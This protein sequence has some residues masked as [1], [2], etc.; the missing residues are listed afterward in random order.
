LLA[1]AA[2]DN[3]I[4]LWD[5]AS[6]QA[7]HEIDAHADEI[8]ALSFGQESAVLASASKDKTVKLWDVATG[9]LLNTLNLKSAVTAVIWHD[10]LYA[11][12]VGKE[13][14]F[15]D[16]KTAQITLPVLKEHS[17]NITAFSWN[18]QDRPATAS[19]DGTVRLWTRQ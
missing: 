15:W 16:G 13:V 14:Q 3:K 19:Q 5:I 4:R 12:A 1:S 11:V 7:K 18:E 8:T 10:G 9:T 6:Q 2:A 17:G